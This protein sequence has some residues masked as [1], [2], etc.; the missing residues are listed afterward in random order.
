[1]RH[2]PEQRVTAI[3]LGTRDIERFNEEDSKDDEGKDPL[4]GDDFDR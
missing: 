2:T 3:V 4:Q 1:M